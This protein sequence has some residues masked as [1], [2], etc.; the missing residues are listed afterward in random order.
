MLALGAGGGSYVAKDGIRC[1]MLDGSFS[2][3]SRSIT[4]SC[5]KL[6]IDLCVQAAPYATEVSHAI[7]CSRPVASLIL[8]DSMYR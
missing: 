5:I 4:T 1:S 3:V 7:R 6:A 2:S 8:K